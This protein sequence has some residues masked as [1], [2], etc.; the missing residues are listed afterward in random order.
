MYYKQAQIAANWWIDQMKKQCNKLYPNKVIMDN[1]TFV[2]IDDSLNEDFA[3]FHKILSS[4]IQFYLEIRSY[5]ALTCHFVP[6]ADL[7]SLARKAKISTTY[8]PHSATMVVN[9]GKIEVSVDNGNLRP[10]PLPTENL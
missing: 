7:S 9:C 6:C 2:V 3:R 1:S 8:F 4:K 10:L 5:L